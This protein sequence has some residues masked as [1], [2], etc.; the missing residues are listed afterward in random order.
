MLKKNKQIKGLNNN[1]H[2]ENWVLK[3]IG[4]FHNFLVSF[5]VLS[6]ANYMINVLLYSFNFER[7]ILHFIPHIWLQALF[8]QLWAKK[9][10]CEVCPCNPTPSVLL[11]SANRV[12]PVLY[13]LK[14]NQTSTL[15]YFWTVP[16]PS[17]DFTRAQVQ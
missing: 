13:F 8:Y 10:V 2:D 9:S 16:I 7:F 3:R 1:H 5:K 4:L 6:V 14:E 11:L 12:R 17:Q 15:S